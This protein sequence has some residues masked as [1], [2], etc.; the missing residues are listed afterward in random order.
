MEW[1]RKESE[2]GYST[3]LRLCESLKQGHPIPKRWVIS[4]LLAD[5]SLHGLPII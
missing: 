3:G 5:E 1:N 4:L 2:P